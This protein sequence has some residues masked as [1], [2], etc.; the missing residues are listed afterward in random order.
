MSEASRIAMSVAA[1]APVAA[2]RR[3]EYMVEF[4]QVMQAFFITAVL[5]GMKYAS[6][7]G[8]VW[9]SSPPD[10]SGRIFFRV[11]TCVRVFLYLS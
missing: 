11:G 2:S 4:R 8:L 6:E 10:D 3:S 7:V 5:S 9:F 1:C